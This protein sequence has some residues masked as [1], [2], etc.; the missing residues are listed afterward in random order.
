MACLRFH[1]DELVNA[2]LIATPG[3]YVTAA[4]IAVRPLVD[5]GLISTDT[6]IVDAASGVTGAGRKED[7]A[8][9]FTTVD[10]T[11]LPTDS[12]DTGIH[13]RWNKR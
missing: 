11:S 2:T 6:V 5:K 3:C 13:Q 12:S 9:A 10:E 8:Y 1:R 7:L 4:I